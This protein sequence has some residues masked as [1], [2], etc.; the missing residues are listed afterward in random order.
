MVPRIG[1][2][3]GDHPAEKNTPNR[4]EDKYPNFRSGASWRR[5]SYCKKGIRMMPVICKPKI[6]TTTPPTFVRIGRNSN[7]R[8]PIADAPKPNKINIVLKPRTK[9]T[10]WLKVYQR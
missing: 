8:L 1:P 9:K 2:T 4:K 6:T 3:Q 7:N 10:P 5:T